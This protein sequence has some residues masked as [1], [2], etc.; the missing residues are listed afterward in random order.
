MRK[1]L[2]RVNK[3]KNQLQESKTL[4]TSEV[5]VRFNFFICCGARSVISVLYSILFFLCFNNTRR[6]QFAAWFA[7]SGDENVNSKLKSTRTFILRM[8]KYTQLLS[9][10][11]FCLTHGI[12]EYRGLTQRYVNKA[13]NI[14]AIR[15]RMAKELTLKTNPI[16]ININETFTEIFFLLSKTTYCI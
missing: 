11:V 2:I 9:N 16:D 6:W 12:Y 5:I 3:V 14:E 1:G 4:S 8:T 13:S 10:I 15:P 7:D